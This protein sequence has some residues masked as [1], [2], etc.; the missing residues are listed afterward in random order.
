MKFLT[1]FRSFSFRLGSIWNGDFKI[2][3][4]TLVCKVSRPRL[5]NI[6]AAIKRLMTYLSL[7]IIWYRHWQW[8]LAQESNLKR[9]DH[10]KTRFFLPFYFCFFSL[11]LMHYV[12]IYLSA[13]L[14]YH[15]LIHLLDEFHQL[16]TSFILNKIT[17]RVFPRFHCLTNDHNVSSVWFFIAQL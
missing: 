13:C 17:L 15:L 12:L 5:S 9:K 8:N 4:K 2:I 16:M 1:A 7:I 11:S 10:K 14:V 6:Q 3:F